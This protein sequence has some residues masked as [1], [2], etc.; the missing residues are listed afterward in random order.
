MAI[1]DAKKNT[2]IHHCAFLNQHRHID[3]YIKYFRKCLE[4]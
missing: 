2:A 1:R 3:L 4:D